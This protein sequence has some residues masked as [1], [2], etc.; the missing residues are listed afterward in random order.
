ME[1]YLRPPRDDRGRREAASSIDPT[2]PDEHEGYFNRPSQLSSEADNHQDFSNPKS[3]PRRR[4]V[5]ELT[6]RG[7]PFKLDWQTE[8]D[9]KVK[10]AQSIA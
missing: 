10:F 8:K 2:A 6:N 3:N 5:S 1:A 7:D 4:D 9:K